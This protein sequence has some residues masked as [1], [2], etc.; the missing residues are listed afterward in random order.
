MPSLQLRPERAVRASLPALLLLVALTPGLLT[1]CRTAAVA[2]RNLDAT[3]SSTDTFRY[4]GPT[5]S[6]WGDLLDR[7]LGSLRGITRQGRPEPKMKAIPNPTRTAQRNLMRLAD[8]KI[9][10]SVWRRNE[11]VRQFARYAATAPSQLARERAL[12]ELPPHV[13][14]LGVTAP[15]PPP[16]G[17][18]ANA[19]QLLVSIDGLVDAARGL[20]DSDAP[21][22]TE[23]LDFEAAVDL[24]ARTDLDIEGGTRLLRAIGPFLRIEG[25]P[26]RAEEALIG[27][28]RDVQARLV[29][30]ALHRGLR[31]PS[32]VARAGAY[33][34]C[35][36]VFGE[37]FAVAALFSLVSRDARPSWFDERYGRFDLPLV[38]AIFSEVHLATLAHFEANGLPGA[39]TSSASLEPVELRWAIFTALGFL[40]T[41][42]DLYPDRTRL[43]A[44]R[45]L[46]SVSGGELRTLREE[47]W[48]AWFRARSEE[49]SSE[50]ERLRADQ[51]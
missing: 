38:P 47:E 49:L 11:Q 2:S 22:E 27:L 17:S 26:E 43:A 32:A 44:M 30:E 12:L 41:Y 25:L 33:R 4:Q 48:A 31:D 9:A 45:A 39:A 50:A 6:V 37:D 20:L 15:T 7:T 19:N 8:A 3:L 34:A 18:A 21:T 16:N 1:G 28:S 29:A 13:E 35:L 36:E 42:R 24:L 51:P 46:G 10:G 40:A 5:I 14:R 23:L